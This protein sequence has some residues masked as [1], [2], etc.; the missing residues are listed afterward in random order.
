MIMDDL[1]KK[2]EALLFVAGEG[3]TIS[4]LASVLKKND[5]EI[6]NA[7]TLLESHLAESHSLVMLK[8][9][10]HVAF[11]TGS[12]VSKVV[13]DFAKEE[14]SEELTRAGLETLAIVAYK[15]PIKRSEIDYIRGV[16]S[17]F[18]VRN[19]L[20]RGLLER[21]RDPKDA[22]AY[23]YRISSD[24]LKFLGVASRAELPEYGD[25]AGKLEEFLKEDTENE[26]K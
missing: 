25:L 10:D 12:A 21:I 19:L 8:D 7:L 15:G 18:T 11:V 22:R 13:E 17:S 5:E 2:I 23:V 6:K 9:G 4:R 26:Q 14:F 1:S 3:M 20:M 24:F 16:N